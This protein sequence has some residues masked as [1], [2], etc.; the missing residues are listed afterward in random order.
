[1]KGTGRYCPVTEFD[2]DHEINDHV[3]NTKNLAK[4][5]ENVHSVNNARAVKKA[6]IQTLIDSL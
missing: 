5:I 4:E 1:M 6:I 2:I 3:E